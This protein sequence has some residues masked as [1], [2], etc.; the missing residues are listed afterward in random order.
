AKRLR[1][2]LATTLLIAAPF[3]VA[4]LLLRAIILPYALATLIATTL[5]GE[6]RSLRVRQIA[7]GAIVACGA[8]AAVT[9]AL[10]ARVALLIM[11]ALVPLAWTLAATSDRVC[12]LPVRVEP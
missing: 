10:E 5:Y 6:H 12:D 9:G 2:L 3:L 4:A 7:D 1:S 11:L 8:F